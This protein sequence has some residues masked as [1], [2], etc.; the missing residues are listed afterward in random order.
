MKT[1]M[2]MNIEATQRS[3]FNAPYFVIYVVDMNSKE[4]DRSLINTT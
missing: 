2:R 3:I 4:V 1:G